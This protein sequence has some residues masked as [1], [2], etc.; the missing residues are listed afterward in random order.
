VDVTWVGKIKS[1]RLM[2]L[3]TI[4]SRFSD[5]PNSAVVGA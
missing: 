4:S 2:P 5:E 1:P 3:T